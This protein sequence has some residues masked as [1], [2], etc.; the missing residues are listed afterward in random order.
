MDQ[1]YEKLMKFKEDDERGEEAAD[2]RA[3]WE[4]LEI[5]GANLQQI[6]ALEERQQIAALDALRGAVEL[7][8]GDILERRNPS[9]QLR[10]PF[11]DDLED[12]DVEDAEG[13]RL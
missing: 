3:A 9:N 2:V 1:Y 4:V 8:Q 10:I 12:F 5:A 6:K 11:G 7:I 13:N